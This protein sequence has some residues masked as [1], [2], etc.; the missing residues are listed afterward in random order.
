MK[1]WV[2]AYRLKDSSL[3]VTPEN[4]HSANPSHAVKFYSEES[5]LDFLK[6]LKS[7]LKFEAVQEHFDFE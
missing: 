1:L 6:D 2:L 7:F 5:A 4:S 3:Y